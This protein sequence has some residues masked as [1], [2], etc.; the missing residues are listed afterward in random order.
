MPDIL[1]WPANAQAVSVFCDMD[2]QWR[3]GMAG[4]TGLDYS[5]LPVVMR[6]CGV[7]AAE[8]A[9]VFS[10]IRVMETE[11]LNTMIRNKVNG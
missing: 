7:P 11:A 8:R 3:I 9:S 4:R 5:A 6:L 1:V 2:T 10:D